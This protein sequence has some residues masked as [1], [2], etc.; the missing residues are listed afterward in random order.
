MQ[1]K[2]ERKSAY[3]ALG[4]SSFQSL[5]LFC[6]VCLFVKGLGVFSSACALLMW[7][8]RDGAAVVLPLPAKTLG[9][10][11]QTAHFEG[12]QWRLVQSTNYTVSRYWHTLPCL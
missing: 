8:F 12:E 10:E 5:Y 2:A 9:D 3:P 1:L 4:S 11:Q 6:A 7:I